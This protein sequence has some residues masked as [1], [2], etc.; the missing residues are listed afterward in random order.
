[1]VDEARGEMEGSTRRPAHR[2]LLDILGL[3]A[4]AGAIITGIDSVRRAAREDKVF[5]V[6]LA[7]DAAPG[8]QGKLTPLLDARKVPFHSIFTRF[9]LGA[10]LGRDS[11]SAVGITD[12][13]FA[14]RTGELVAAL[15]EDRF[16][17]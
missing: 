5:R 15:S 11:V 13:R 7:D 1:V 8:Q 2:R 9:E 4:R 17:A 14:K 12:R 10:A 16:T 3:A 6:I